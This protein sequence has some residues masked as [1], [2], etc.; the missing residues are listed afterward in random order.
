[1]VDPGND[2]TKGHPNEDGPVVDPTGSNI[3]RTET[4]YSKG[5]TPRRRFSNI[6]NDMT[7]KY[8]IFT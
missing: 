5:P 3:N 4:K 8:Q 2:F 7:E 1:M 6:L